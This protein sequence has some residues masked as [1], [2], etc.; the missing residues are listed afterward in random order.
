M[1][2]FVVYILYS[3]ILDKYYVGHTEDTDKRLLQHNMGFST[4]TA[5]A[6]DWIL[7]YKEIFLTRQEAR[8]REKDI[9]AKKSRKYIEWLIRSAG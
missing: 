9:K 4:Y 3:S 1:P 8:Q 7:V 6:Q 2:S 5:K